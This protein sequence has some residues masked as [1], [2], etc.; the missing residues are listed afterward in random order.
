MEDQR[1]ATIRAADGPKLLGASREE[2]LILS[3]KEGRPKN[4][5]PELKEVVE[6]YIE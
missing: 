5:P 1:I 3:R 4:V 2:H 6:D